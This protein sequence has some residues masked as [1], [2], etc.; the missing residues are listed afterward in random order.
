[1]GTMGSL[2]LIPHRRG[3]LGLYSNL[4]CVIYTIHIKRRLDHVCHLESTVT[5]TLL[6]VN[7]R[8]QLLSFLYNKHPSYL[9]S[10]FH[11]ASSA[12]TRNLTVPP[13]RTLTMSQSFVVLFM[14]T[15]NFQ[16]QFVM[17]VET[18]QLEILRPERLGNSWINE[19]EMKH[20]VGCQDMLQ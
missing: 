18:F 19:K 3:D 6:V 11:F 13:H 17:P 7:N 10:L 16:Y 9:F 12:R 4:V 15:L 8:I 5:G 14:R 20:C 2:V 1:M